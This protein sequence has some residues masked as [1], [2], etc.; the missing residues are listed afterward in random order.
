MYTWNLHQKWAVAFSSEVLPLLGVIKALKAEI[1]IV[2]L[3]IFSCILSVKETFSRCASP[4]QCC[5]ISTGHRLSAGTMPLYSSDGIN[6]TMHAHKCKCTHRK[7]CCN[8]RCVTLSS[9]LRQSW[10][11]EFPCALK[12]QSMQILL[13]FHYIS[14]NRLAESHTNRPDAR[15]LLMV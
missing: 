14:L 5:L 12:H 1:K 11:K 15:I 9:P 6:T 13:E 3:H 10:E 8:R 7:P 4:Y 2:P